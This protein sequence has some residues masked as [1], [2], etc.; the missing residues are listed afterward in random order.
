MDSCFR[1]NDRGILMDVP[2]QVEYWWV[3]S[4]EDFAAAQSLLEKGHLRHCLFFAHLAIEKMLKAHVTKQ[5]KDIPP[6][7]HNL[8]R[9]AEIAD[10]KLDAERAEFLREFG[11]YQLEGRYP[12]FEQVPVDSDLAQYEISRA[13]EM[14][15]WLKKQL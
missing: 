7:I 3:S 5:T 8:I 6:R 15:I 1:R 13:K 10:P 4:D 11:I 2:K 14:L 12:D 9:L